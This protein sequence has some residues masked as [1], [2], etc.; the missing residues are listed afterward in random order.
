MTIVKLAKML[1]P[2]E[3]SFF[4]V[5]VGLGAGALAIFFNFSFSVD[6]E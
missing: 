6:L 4:A 3:L 2:D 1:E 5:V